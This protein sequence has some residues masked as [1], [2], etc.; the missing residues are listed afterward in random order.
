MYLKYF[1]PRVD[2]ILCLTTEMQAIFHRQMP[3]AKEK[4]IVIPKGHD[5]AWYANVVASDRNELGFT[6]DDLLLCIV[7]NLRPFKGIRYLLDAIG[8]L[9]PR[10]DCHFLM[11]GKGYDAPAVRQ[12]IDSLV[13]K[14]RIHLLGHRDDALSVIAACDGLILPS[15]HGEGL[16]KSVLEAQCLRKPVIVTDI[17][18]NNVI[19]RDGIGGWVVPPA[20][21][22]ALARGP[23]GSSGRKNASRSPGTKIHRSE[24]AHP[25]YSQSIPG[26]LPGITAWL[27]PSF[28]SIY[29]L[30]AVYRRA[31][32]A[33]FTTFQKADT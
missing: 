19:V 24:S 8:M 22:T 9:D 4:A 29:F 33:Q 27:D 7:A 14:D 5:P 10:M 16:N 28:R 15:T 6:P 17:P 1:H 32:S 2:R 21:A 20:D 3:W 11:I 26:S 18:G 30:A 12:K 13:M 25:R 23:C 31:T